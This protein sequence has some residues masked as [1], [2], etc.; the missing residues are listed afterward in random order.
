MIEPKK[1]DEAS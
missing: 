1:F